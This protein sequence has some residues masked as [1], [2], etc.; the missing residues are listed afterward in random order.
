MERFLD[1]K[2]L[3]PILLLIVLAMIL[4]PCA[5]AD[6]FLEA[7]SGFISVSTGNFSVSG[8]GF[9]FTGF[10]TLMGCPS[11]YAPGQP[12]Q[13]C[14][15]GFPIFSE[16]NG[17]LVLNGV[18]QPAADIDSIATGDQAPMFL[19]GATQATLTEP[20]F[21]SGVFYGCLG[22]VLPCGGSTPG[23]PFTISTDGSMEFSI[24]LTQIPG[25]GYEVTNEVY[26]S[27][28][29]EPGTEVLLLSGVGLLFGLMMRKRI[30]NCL[31]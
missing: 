30:A 6:V 15:T 28:T 7:T 21:L 12:I 11:F 18:T 26:T 1:M 8:P 17:T 4:A 9:T 14:S 27:I 23:E 2:R 19:S 25:G 5:K 13:G 29:P 22:N 31:A 24:S 3:F 10:V 20:A 16:G